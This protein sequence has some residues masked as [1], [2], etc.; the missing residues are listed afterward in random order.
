MSD[1][2]LTVTL[3]STLTGQHTG[4]DLPLPLIISSQPVHALE[5]TLVTEVLTV[6]S[7]FTDVTLVSEGTYL[8]IHLIRLI[9]PFCLSH[10]IYLFHMILLVSS[11]LAD[12]PVSPDLHDSPDPPIHM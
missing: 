9:H 2:P 8:L 10:L 6:S 7:D 3:A 5:V 1:G 12:S 4:Q 11:D